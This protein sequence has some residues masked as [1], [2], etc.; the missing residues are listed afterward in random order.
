[1]LLLVISALA[2]CTLFVT[3]EPPPSSLPDAGVEDAGTDAAG[4]VDA[5]TDGGLEAPD[6][7]EG[8]ALGDPCT[9]SLDCRPPRMI[10]CANVCLEPHLCL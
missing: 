5:G 9:D 6:A 3:C 2:L 8:P 4:S 10:C 1:V 7:Y